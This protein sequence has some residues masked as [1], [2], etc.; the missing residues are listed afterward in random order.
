MAYIKGSS[1]YQITFLPDCLDDYVSADNS[2][3]IIEAFVQQLDMASLGFK[4]EPAAEGRPGYDPRDMLKLYIYGYLNKIRS[5]RKLQT[6][7]GRNVE[8]MW[9]LGKIVPD[10]RCIADFRKDN[11]K[12]IKNVFR[13]FVMLCDKAKLLSHET[14]VIDGSKFRAVNSDNNCYVKSNVEK[15][16]AQADERITKYMAELDAAD[17]KQRRNEELTSD[18]IREVLAYLA[19]RKVQLENALAKL[20]ENGLNHVCTTDPESRL[21]KTRDGFKPSFN[22]QTVVESD[23]HIIVHF[24]VTND[25]ADWGLL[26]AGISGAKDIL[27]METLEG[28]ADKGYG[29][30]EEILNCLLNGDTPTVYPNKNQNCRTFK[31]AKTDEEINPEMLD[32]ADHE[33]LKKCIA[34]GTLPNVLKRD[35]ITFEIVPSATPQQFLDKETGELV[36]YEQKKAAGGTVREELKLRL[37]SPVQLYFERDLTTDTVICPMGHTLFYAGIAWTNGKADPDRRRYHRASVCTKC[38]NKCTVGKQ[39]II[40]FKADEIRKYTDFYSKCG[41]GR[42]TRRKA[43]RFIPL[44]VPKQETVI[45][46]YYPNQRKL[47]IR[48]Q[49]VEHPYGTVKRWNDGYYLLVK[50]KVK[51]T[52]E[53]AL[54]FL[55]YNMKRA[56]K[57]LGTQRLL[58]LINA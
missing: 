36:S 29:N 25:C 23:H 21:M 22:V 55:G 57:L 43:R 16:I 30:D 40:S 35:D 6:E 58:E 27:G 18:N 12:A 7:A 15:L 44:D 41:T 3:R 1:K 52:A 46:K 53:L 32:S 28:I 10:F 19:K 20:D 24:D 45:L 2:V 39:R 33:I 51:A 11:A 50:G 17:E 47:R 31:F 34:A 4:A 8:L 5:S 26:E 48:N 42:I 37:K 13:E 9:L 54:S 14:V 56:V 49:I 38:N